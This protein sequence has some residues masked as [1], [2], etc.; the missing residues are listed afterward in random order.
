MWLIILIILAFMF[1]GGGH[2]YNS[3]QYS[4]P[5][6]GLGTL[7]LIVVLWLLFTRSY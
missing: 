5:G 7:L 6:F 1:F 4:T 2:Y 3:G